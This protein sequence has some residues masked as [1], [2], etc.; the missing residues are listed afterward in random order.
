MCD[1]RDVR[2]D[3]GLSIGD[4]A[5]QLILSFAE[6]FERKKKKKKRDVDRE[7]CENIAETPPEIDIQ[8]RMM[9]HSWS[10]GA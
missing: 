5:G 3:T 6:F 2:G 4:G 9:E 7:C 10:P 8:S 1:N